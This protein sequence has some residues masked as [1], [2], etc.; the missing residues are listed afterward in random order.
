MVVQGNPA[1][2]APADFEFAA[3]VA[4]VK[5]VVYLGDY[6]DETA[7]LAG[8][9]IPAAHALES[10]ADAR[11]Y[12]GTASLVQPLIAPLHGGRTVAELLALFAGEDDPDPR[13]MLR[14]SWER[15]AGLSDLDARWEDALRRG[16]VAGSAAPRRDHDIA[17]APLAAALAKMPAAPPAAGGLEVSFA[18]DPNVY[19]G[20]F[21][22]NA[23]LI[24]LPKPLTHLTWDNA[25]HLAPATA[26]RLGLLDED[27]VDLDLAGRTRARAGAHR[28][29]TRGGRG[30]APPGLGAARRGRVGRRGP[31]GSTRT[32]CARRAPRGSRRASRSASARVS[33]TRS[34]GRS[35]S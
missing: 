19:D 23:W 22:N 29:G 7:A 32:C 12:D 14:R 5:D 10:W 8:W 21:T 34:R 1:Y 33:T 31:S 26:A 30:H 9:F 18:V 11:A 15:R 6:E 3:R 24:E 16:L 20:R 28:R 17:A 4:K 27:V 35:S 25:V 13:R 2:S